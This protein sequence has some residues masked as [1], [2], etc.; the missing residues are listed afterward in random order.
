MSKTDSFDVVVVGGG[1]I[2][3]A[4]AWRAAQ[5]GLSVCVLERDE[6]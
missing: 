3:L 4:C 5:R 2:G 1:A 6:P